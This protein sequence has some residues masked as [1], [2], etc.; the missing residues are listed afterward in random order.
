MLRLRK[1]THIFQPLQVTHGAASATSSMDQQ[2]LPRD[3]TR[4]GE[5]MGAMNDVQERQP[6]VPPSS[7]PQP[8][9]S[10]HSSPSLAPVLLPFP[11]MSPSA[12][13]SAMPISGSGGSMSHTLTSTISSTLKCKESAL[14]AAQ[15][16]SSGSKRQH[17]SVTG[18]I[19][20]NGI[21]ESL[22]T[23]N[24]AFRQSI[25]T[26]PE[27]SHADTSPEHQSKA[28]ESLQERETDI[29]APCIVALLDLFQANTASVDTYLAIKQDE[30]RLLWIERQLMKDL[31]FPAMSMSD[32][33]V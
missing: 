24:T 7:P 17:T 11:A 27:C 33:K 12:I 5:G 25:L 14:S 9:S 22:D 4:E 18:V 8:P 10:P 26:Q 16:I 21:K 32:L 28:M 3:R 23:F 13:P 30:V 31:G 6:S 20:L 29:D 15:S 2:V 1:G 19:I